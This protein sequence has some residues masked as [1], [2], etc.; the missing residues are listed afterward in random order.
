MIGLLLVFSMDIT[1]QSKIAYE[2][3]GYIHQPDEPALVPIL[4]F[5]TNKQWH[6][7]MRYNYEDAKTLSLFGGKTF[8]TGNA[9][10]C[11]IT[12]MA[13]FSA[14]NFTG[15]SLAANTE[16][17]WNKFYLW[18]QSQYSKATKTNI[19][20]FF[21][22]WS[23]LGYEITDNFFAGLTMQYT[24]EIGF[25]K[26]EPGFTAGFSYKDVT[27]PIYVFNPF[28]HGSYFVFG[29]TY[30]YTMKKRTKI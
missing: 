15:I 1:A 22:N 13:G 11:K 9:L 6:C 21:F 12:P 10:A 3:Y 18:A 4:R 26:L 20:D 8:T 29:L 16:A 5:E 19:A 17:T 2:Q 28:Q 27:I 30:E 25:N 23:E 24:R 14:G 7:E